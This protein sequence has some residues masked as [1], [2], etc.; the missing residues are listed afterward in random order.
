MSFAPTPDQTA[1]CAAV[2]EFARARLGSQMIQRDR[3]AQFD[4]EGF[5]LCGEMGIQGLTIPEAYGGQAQDHATALAVLQALGEACL[6]NGLLFSLNAQIWSVQMPIYRYGTPEQKDRYLPG[7]CDG[8]RIGVHA[9]SEPDSGS[10]ALA[11]RTRAV[12]DGDGY[13][14]DGTKTFATNAPVGDFAVVFAN[15]RPELKAL[16]ITAFLVDRGTPGVT[17]GPPIEK[18]GLRTSPMGEVVL[19]GARIPASARLGGEGA[20]LML[21][22]SSMEYE[23]AFIFASHLGTLR[24]ILERCMAHAKTRRQFGQPIA[25]FPAVFERLVSMRTDLELGEL[26]LRKI[27]GAKDGATEA[28]MEAAMA[29]LFISE[30]YVRATL[31]AIQI[32][33]G[34]GYMTEYEMEREHRDAVASRIYSGTSEIQRKMIAH[35]MG[36]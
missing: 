17:F 34:Y 8:S 7:L 18:M 21:F 31:D 3:D 9:M 27:A 20:G 11:L 1:L 15:L 5:R 13:V 10:D 32:F 4:R 12:R 33:G 29:K 2:Q 28:P 22:Q 23:R 19:E 24:R 16:G 36:L 30:A 26:L 14:L 35:Y 25:K 6:D